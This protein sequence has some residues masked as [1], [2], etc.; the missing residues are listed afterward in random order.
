[1][2]INFSSVENM[3]EEIHLKIFKFRVKEKKWL[4]KVISKSSWRGYLTKEKTYFTMKSTGLRINQSELSKA[5]RN[6][7]VLSLHQN[8]HRQPFK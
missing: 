3:P 6:F 8:I 2:F 1:M 5:R 4:L 7:C